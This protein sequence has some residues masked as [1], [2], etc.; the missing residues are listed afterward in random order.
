MT[1]RHAGPTHGAHLGAHIW[2]PCSTPSPSPTHRSLLSH[3]HGTTMYSAWDALMHLIVHL[4]EV[5]LVA[6]L[7]PCCWPFV[8]LLAFCLV[9]GLSASPACA[10]LGQQSVGSPASLP[11]PSPFSRPSM[12]ARRFCRPFSRPCARPEAATLMLLCKASLCCCVGCR[13][14]CVHAGCPNFLK[15]LDTRRA[16]VAAFVTCHQPQDA[17]R[18]LPLCCR[19]WVTA[20]VS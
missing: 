12:C 10:L 13:K 18:S 1:T 3:T 15:Q 19:L 14:R 5:C 7:L 9:A 8:L 2:T 6:G 17:A 11:T 16:Q 4:K 20:P